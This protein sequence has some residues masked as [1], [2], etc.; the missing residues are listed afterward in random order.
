MGPFRVNEALYTSFIENTEGNYKSHSGQ[1]VAGSK[2]VPRDS[3]VNLYTNL[4]GVELLKCSWWRHG[5]L[6]DDIFVFWR[7][8][9]FIC[10]RSLVRCHYKTVLKTTEFS[11]CYRRQVL[12][13]SSHLHLR[14]SVLW[15][16]L[17]TYNVV[18]SKILK[19]SDTPIYCYSR[20]LFLYCLIERTGEKETAF[21]SG[22]ETKDIYKSWRRKTIWFHYSCL[23][24]VRRFNGA[25]QSIQ[26]VIDQ[27]SALLFGLR[28]DWLVFWNRKTVDSIYWSIRGHNFIN[29]SHTWFH[30]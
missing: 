1:R 10:C 12:L 14:S 19:D 27:R 26:Q 23:D 24:I 21:L 18:Y 4:P 16:F 29:N 15:V 5:H 17:S 25:T 28:A 13:Y 9:G 11:F 22:K 3:V 20:P 30:I 6:V 2:F 7:D 8:M